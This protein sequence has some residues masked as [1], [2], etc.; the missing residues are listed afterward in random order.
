[1]AKRKEQVQKLEG[2][3]LYSTAIAFLKK[4]DKTN[5]ISRAEATPI[6]NVIEGTNKRPNDHCTN[7]N[8]Y[9]VAK[10]NKIRN[11]ATR[12]ERAIKAREENE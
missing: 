7:C 3:E 10:V 2:D 12:Y 9:W 6:L 1:M 8:D 4:Y 5:R 11:F